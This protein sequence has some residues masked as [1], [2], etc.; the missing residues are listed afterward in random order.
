MTSQ[1]AGSDTNCIIQP[2]DHA[3]VKKATVMEYEK[4]KFLTKQGQDAIDKMPAQCPRKAPVSY[5]LLKRIQEGALKSDLAPEN[6]KAA[7]TASIAKQAN[8]GP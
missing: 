6:V 4:A 1:R 5:A 3:F 8:S 2:S 7:I